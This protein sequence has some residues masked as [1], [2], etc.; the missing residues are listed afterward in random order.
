M[1]PVREFGE[2]GWSDRR[3]ISEEVAFECKSERLE[4]CKLIL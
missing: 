2:F 1:E 4:F 3:G